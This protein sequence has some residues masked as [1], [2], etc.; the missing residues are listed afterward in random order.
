VGCH[1]ENNPVEQALCL[2][3]IHVSN[4]SGSKS[5]VDRKTDHA[6]LLLTDLTELD[7]STVAL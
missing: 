2:V 6:P 3:D 5:N 7:V 4:A 1:A